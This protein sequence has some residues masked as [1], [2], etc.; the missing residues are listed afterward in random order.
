MVKK[1]TYFRR[2]IEPVV[3]ADLDKKMVFIGG[4]RQSGKTTLAK[5]VADNRKLGPSTYLNWDVPADRRIILN[6]TFPTNAKTIVLDEIHKFRRWR[7]VVKGLFDS[8]RDDCAIIVTGSARLDHYRRGGDSL[9]G[10]YHYH[11]LFPFTL[12]EVGG[13]PGDLDALL[14]YG[15][16]PEPFCLGSETQ[17]RRWSR[18]YMSRVV[19]IDLRDLERVMDL[20]LVQ[21]L[22]TRMPAL[23]GSPLSINTLREDLQVSHQ[24][25]ARWVQLLENIYQIFRI[26]PFG[27]PGIKAVKKEPKHYHFDWTLVE[28]DGPRFEN[29]VACQL[30]GWCCRK[31]DAEGLDF[32]LRYFR[33]TDKKEVDFVICKGETPFYCIE[34][35]TGSTE[36]SDG[37]RY[38]KTKYPKVT[39]VQ[40]VLKK[41]ADFVSRDGIRVC[42]AAAFLKDW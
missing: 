23:V 13:A 30:Y 34:C 9:Q 25:C 3:S 33:T 35:K 11:R 12:P 42:N 20:A 15:G 2:A 16:F 26:Y 5:H 19:D 37:L 32:T 31:Q 18:E 21:L 17:S 38:F 14:H 39:A 7:Q 28:E 10:R 27:G 36:I 4:P 22:L 8:R 40:L 29:L 24:T 1:T 6:E 41:S